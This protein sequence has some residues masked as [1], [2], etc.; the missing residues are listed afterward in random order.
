MVDIDIL[1]ST[2]ANDQ[3]QIAQKITRLL[4]PSYFPSRININEACNRCV[5]LMKRSPIAGARFCEF[6]TS[7]GASLDSV[8]ELVKV[9][10]RLVLSDDKLSTDQMEGFLVGTA[11]LCNSLASEPCYKNSL[12]E[13]FPI[14]KVRKLFASAS[15]G[16]SQSSV[17]QIASIVSPN[18]VAE[19]LKDC[20]GLIINCSGLSEDMV[21]Q[22][23]VRSAHKLF[24]SCNSFSDIFDAL[25]EL[26]Q[27]VTYRCH[28]KFDTEIPKQSVSSRKRRKSKSSMKA[29]VK[30]KHV[31]GNRSSSF[32]EDYSLA[33]GVAWQMKDMLLSEDSRMAVLESESLELSFFALKVISEVSILQC[34]DHDYMDVYPVLTYTALALQIT[35]QNVCLSSA[36]HFS[37]QKISGSEPSP[38]SSKVSCVCVFF[39]GESCTK[40]HNIYIFSFSLK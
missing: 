22:T 28:V 39:F 14:N 34:V 8:M 37:S 31:R 26:L 23:E 4:L 38:S 20:M 18:N 5:T 27:K 24:L 15:N 2:L 33:V 17:I 21:R 11:N 16:R 9:F 19:L 1:L 36:N 12:K 35:L 29:S 25:N 13:L 32:E 6:V 3:S 7:E 10:V 40:L 30:W